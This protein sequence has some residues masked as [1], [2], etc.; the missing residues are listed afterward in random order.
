MRASLLK[1]SNMKTI[2]FDLDFTLINS[3]KRTPLVNGSLDLITYRAMQTRENI[4]KDTHEPLIKPFK[5]LVK[6]KKHK[7]VICTA[8][9]MLKAD[10][11]YL[12]FHGINCDLLLNRNI[13]TEEIS[14]LNDG[15]Y[16]LALLKGAGIS[17]KEAI[18]F[19]DSPKV[20]S[21]LRKH[22]LTVICA[23]K[24]NKRLKAKRNLTS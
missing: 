12:A 4:F 10:Y 16:K 18:L 6:N 5:K 11:D 14:A 15:E 19:D 1:G 13:A 20:K 22:G 7:I 2:I 24:A 17:F 3:G 21:V 9:Y 8:R 23:I